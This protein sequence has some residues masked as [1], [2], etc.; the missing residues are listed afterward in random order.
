M[1][2]NEIGST[3]WTAGAG[4]GWDWCRTMADSSLAAV[5]VTDPAFVIS[6]ANEEA[7]RVLACP[8]KRLAGRSFLEFVEDKSLPLLRYYQE[9]TS[10]DDYVS[11]RF[12]FAFVRADGERRLADCTLSRLDESG[13]APS[14]AIQ[15]MDLTERQRA[16]EELKS[17][18]E[19]FRVIFE[20]APDVIYLT[21]L[22]GN[23]VDGNKMAETITGFSK[24]ELVGRNFV[25]AGLLSGD[26][27]P[28]AAVLLAKNAR[29]RPTGPDEFVLTRR[30]G[31]R[32]PVEISAYP[33][34]LGGK[35]LV[36]G[37]ARDIS[38]RRRAEE[39][40]ARDRENLENLVRERTAELEEATR[41]ADAASRAKSAFLANMSHEIRTPINA[42]MGFS[43]LLQRD[44]ALSAEQ[45]KHLSVINRSGE[46]LLAVITDILEMSKIEAG[47]TILNPVTFDLRALVGD[48]ELMFG[49]RCDG[50]RLT[51][52]AE[53]PG[54]DPLYLEGDEGKLRQVLFNLLGNAV[55]FT[56]AGRIV[57]RVRASR[58][59]DGRVEVEAEV[60]DTGPGIPADE[61]A[62][63]FEPFQQTQA[64]RRAKAG[65][66][67]G[68]A[69]CKEYVTLMGGDISVVS[70]PGEGSCFKFHVPMRE[71]DVAAADKAEAI[72]VKRLRPGR[73]ERRV[74]IADDE[75][76]DGAFLTKLLGEVGF[77]TRRAANGKAALE[78]FSAWRPHLIILD[79]RMPEMNGHE[80]ARRIRAAE[81]GAD[82]KIIAVSAAAF[83]ED[84]KEALEAGADDFLTKPFREA[85]IFERIERLLGVE[86]EFETD[87]SGGEV[88]AHDADGEAP[89]S[90]DALA[91]L[92][93]PLLKKM[94]KA[95]IQADYDRMIGVV[96]G[97]E[98]RHPPLAEGLRRLVERFEYGRLLE[99]LPSETPE[100]SDR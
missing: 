14:M 47:Q 49:M 70:R 26:Q 94:R 78:E 37:I 1:G 79:I 86:Y 56:E 36:L 23:F 31:S 45:R 33:I 50:K 8:R 15:F 3:S 10:W 2:E 73:P 100:R 82:V 84:R 46:H 77:Q 57:L 69:I 19:I 55:K 44:G 72:R 92:P 27:M 20:S 63:L 35:T 93:R 80:A 74:L 71:G 32:V 42:I 17:S 13:T 39:E 9:C 54:D 5:V 67:L 75:D 22:R 64:G 48:L 25:A 76:L 38:A 99:L 95:V 53:G 98:S 28:K 24:G 4:P 34:K 7:A 18:F 60:E 12:E 11:S 59:E 65:T 66:G 88:R 43:Q 62:G 83:A 90:A 52:I 16:R 21:D 29:G 89:V 58:L 91:A 81:G 97:L 85:A 68:L 40:Q 96:E 41:H 6:Y 87:P 51:F 30:D 61:Q